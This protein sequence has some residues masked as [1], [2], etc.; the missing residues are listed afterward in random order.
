MELTAAIEGLSA[1]TA[2]PGEALQRQRIFGGC[3]AKRLDMG[4]EKKWLGSR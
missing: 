3:P 1:E 2:M 4:L